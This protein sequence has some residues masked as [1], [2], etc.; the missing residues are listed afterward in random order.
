RKSLGRRLIAAQPWPCA[1]AEEREDVRDLLVFEM[2][3]GRHAAVTIEHRALE[4]RE[5]DL[6]AD[7]QQRR[8]RGRAA[9]ILP[10]AYGA[11]FLV[12]LLATLDFF[13]ARR[14]ETRPRRLHA[15]FGLDLQL[16]E[17]GEV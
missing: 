9:A 1:A 12:Q 10:V 14:P 4:L 17:R 13:R 16:V 6:H 15:L 3:D 7:G 2:P 11:G 5:P 8:C